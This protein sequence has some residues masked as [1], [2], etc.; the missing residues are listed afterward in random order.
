[1]KTNSK[2]SDPANLDYRRSTGRAQTLNETYPKTLHSGVLHVFAR[3]MRFNDAERVL[4][5]H[6]ER[7][8]LAVRLTIHQ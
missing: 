2:I 7:K 4:F 8:A 6:E 5:N 1:M 3:K